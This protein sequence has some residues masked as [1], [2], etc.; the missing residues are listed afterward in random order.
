MSVPNK[1]IITVLGGNGFVGSRCINFLLQKN[2]DIKINMIS[3]SG[4]M[5]YKIDGRVN[6]IKGD[7]LYP[8]T[9]KDAI[10][11]STG[12]IHAVGVLFTNNNEEYQKINKQTALNVALIANNN[13][14]K[15]NFVYVSASRGI[16]F[17]LSI[18][19]HGYLD[20]KRQAETS[21]LNDFNNINPI[22][23]RPGFV[24]SEIK[25]WTY[26][27]YYS[28]GA[29]EALEQNILSK[30]SQNMGEKLQLPSKGIEL[31]RLANFAAEAALGNLEGK[32]IY[33]ND[34]II[35]YKI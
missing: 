21:L 19:Y 10:D 3:R 11:E 31:D 24:K 2:N 22:I 33:S 20:S 7:A 15:P 28:V 35:N 9:F 16:P 12:I 34:E 1:A 29:I 25:K 23:L 18:K 6:V 8:E 13:K 4:N 14:Y 5:K 30:V 32:R 17:P 26:P 27:I